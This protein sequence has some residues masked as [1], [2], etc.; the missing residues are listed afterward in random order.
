MGHVSPYPPDGI[1]YPKKSPVGETGLNVGELVRVKPHMEIRKTLNDKG[2]NRGLWFDVEMVPFCGKEFHV[3]RR[4][5]KI[6]NEET[7][8]MMHM[9]GPCIMLQGVVCKAQYS[10]RR[11]LCPRAIP[12]FWREIWLERVQE[13]AQ[14]AEPEAAVSTPSNQEAQVATK[15][16]R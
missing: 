15:A 10:D 7:G 1:D 4:V 12:S 11:L 16:K 8:E 3:S 9:K 2:L 6:I 14:A 5:Q 13:N